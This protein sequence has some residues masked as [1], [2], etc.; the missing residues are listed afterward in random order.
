MISS[1]SKTT[2]IF[3]QPGAGL[4][5]TRNKDAH[6][7]AGSYGVIYVNDLGREA[8]RSAQP[9]TFPT[10]SII[11]REKLAK[12]DA[13]Q[14]QLV[15]VMVKRPTGFSPKSGDWEYLILDGA[16][17]KI[18]ERQKKGACLDCHESQRSRDFVFS[19]SS[20]K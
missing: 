9:T 3:P 12:I 13:S 10:G 11:V 17:K 1:G 15:A 6:D 5:E 18:R 7:D 2:F 20:T 14:P 4:S 19:V 8:M 16:A